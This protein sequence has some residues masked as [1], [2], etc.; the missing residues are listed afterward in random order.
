MGTPNELSQVDLAKV[1]VYER[2]NDNRSTVLDRIS[3]LQGDEP[4][5]GYDELNVEEVRAALG[6]DE[7]R[8]ACASTSVAQEPH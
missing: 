3:P 6:D 5:P 4:W 8:N 1:A 2:K 7:Q